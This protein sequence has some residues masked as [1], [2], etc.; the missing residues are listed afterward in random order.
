MNTL[1]KET[2]LYGRS[3]Y[4]VWG[5]TETKEEYTIEKLQDDRLY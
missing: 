5:E 4:Y 2:V 3:K 1:E